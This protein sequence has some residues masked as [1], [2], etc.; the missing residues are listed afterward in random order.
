MPSRSQFD[1]HAEFEKTAWAWN[2]ILDR[3][4]GFLGLNERTVPSLFSRFLASP[5]SAFH[6]I[7]LH[8]IAASVYLKAR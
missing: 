6:H 5:N 8:N 2:L 3:M 7:S 4:D 1:S